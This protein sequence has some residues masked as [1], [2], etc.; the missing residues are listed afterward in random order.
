MKAAGSVT[1]LRS[2]LACQGSCGGCSEA[3]R[4]LEPW[5][6]PRKAHAR[7]W[8]S[9][10]CSSS[11]C[12]HP[13]AHRQL[14]RKTLSEILVLLDISSSLAANQLYKD[15]QAEAAM[16]CMIS[17]V[18]RAMRGLLAWEAAHAAACPSV[19]NDRRAHLLGE[20]STPD[21]LASSLHLPRVMRDQ[22]GCKAFY[23]HMS[24]WYKPAG[25][26]TT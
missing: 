8:E 25:R 15:T 2:R 1:H 5:V 12:R 13:S 7:Q 24:G 21:G 19:R 14:V 17:E 3:C 16:C 20:G 18:G 23:M 9:S 22:N 6:T 10:R 4:P 11:C 26:A